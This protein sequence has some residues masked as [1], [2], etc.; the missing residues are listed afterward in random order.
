MKENLTNN[1]IENK[2]NI[3]W[4]DENGNWGDALNKILCCNLSELDINKINTYTKNSIYRYYCIGSILEHIQSPNFEVW[5][6]GFISEN[7]KLKVRPDKIHAVRGPLT[8]KKLIKQGYNCPEVYGDPALLYP[9]FYKPNVKKKYA[10]GI[11]PH[12][13]DKD[14]EWLKQFNNQ[15]KVKII[16][17]I[18]STAKRF[19]NEINECEVILSSS[20]HGIICGDSYGIP[21]YWIELSDKVI[22]KGYKFRDYFLSVDRPIKD[23]IKPKLNQKIEDIEHLFYDYKINIDLNKLLN[24]CPFYKKN[25][26]NSKFISKFNNEIEEKNIRKGMLSIKIRSILNRLKKWI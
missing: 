11:I 26:K 2:L 20:L 1:T 3:S 6:S 7:G 12:L 22:G 4:W 9:M 25:T 10:Y 19:V 16:D 24:A 23:S 14:N 13:I 8:R 5:G 15:S 21:S 17:I 18:D